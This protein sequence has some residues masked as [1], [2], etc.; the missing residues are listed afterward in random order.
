MKKLYYIGFSIPVLVIFNLLFNIYNISI[1]KP[2]NSKLLVKESNLIKS[3]NETVNCTNNYSIEELSSKYMNG[4]VEIN[5][6]NS[7]GTGFVVKHDLN[8]T[9][10]ITNSHVVKR[11]N[12]V[13]IKWSDDTTNI[14]RLVFDGSGSSRFNDLALLEIDQLKGV[15]LNLRKNNTF[16]G[17]DVVAIGSPKGIGFTLTKGIIS[18]IRN[19]GKIVQTDAAINPGNSGGPLIEKSGCVAGINTFI[20]KDTEGL[21][22]AISSILVY[23]FLNEYLSNPKNKSFHISSKKTGNNIIY[24]LKS[25]TNNKT[26]NVKKNITIAPLSEKSNRCPNILYTV[27]NFK[28]HIKLWDKL[29]LKYNKVSSISDAYEVIKITCSMLSGKWKNDNYLAYYKRAMARAYLKHYVQSIN[30]LDKG[31]EFAPNNK[32]G[33]GYNNRGILKINI[34]NVIDGCIDFK[35]ATSLGY[36]I[37][38]SIYIKYCM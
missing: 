9:L 19:E 18:A 23:K 3:N 36:E 27:N 1:N 11:N 12:N 17:R 13:L 29:N 21:N 4:V 38:E 32:K 28:S 6:M 30:D 24:P 26:N 31:I 15:V 37:D 33:L 35:K 14:A 10:I 5:T 25:T 7:S 2:K 16:I 22:F 8:R 20:M 34:N